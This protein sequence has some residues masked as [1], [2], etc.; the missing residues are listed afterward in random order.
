[1]QFVIIY[2]E[3]INKKNTIFIQ[4]IKLKKYYI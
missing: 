2:S 3:L 4:S 1:M